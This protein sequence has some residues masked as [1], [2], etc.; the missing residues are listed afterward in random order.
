MKDQP[1][2]KLWWTE[3]SRITKR[4]LIHYRVCDVDIRLA[5]R[6]GVCVFVMLW[7]L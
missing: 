7:G 1:E 5:V 6:N 2:Q 4:V 3:W